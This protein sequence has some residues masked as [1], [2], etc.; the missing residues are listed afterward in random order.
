VVTDSQELR[1]RGTEASR[2]TGDHSYPFLLSHCAQPLIPCLF[3]AMGSHREPSVFIQ[4][5]IF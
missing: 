1:Y 3:A 2:C 5:S 4:G